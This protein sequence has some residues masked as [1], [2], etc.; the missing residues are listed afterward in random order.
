MVTAT[1][2]SRTRYNTV[3]KE[4]KI[5][6]TR[7]HET[8]PH[9]IQIHIFFVTYPASPLLAKEKAVRGVLQQ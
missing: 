6:G 5:G 3:K 2:L 1:H 4:K 8:Q 9:S 7:K